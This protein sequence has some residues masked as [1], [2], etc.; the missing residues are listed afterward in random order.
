MDVFPPQIMGPNAPAACLK[1]D[2]SLGELLVLLNIGTPRRSRC[3][4]LRWA[5]VENSGVAEARP[6]RQEVQQ[7]RDGDPATRSRR[8]RLASAP[9]RSGHFTSIL[10]CS[11]RKALEERP[12]PIGSGRAAISPAALRR[13]VE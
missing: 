2:R 10:A 6:A 8:P 7:Q 12:E 1:Q 9:A 13:G 3:C 4:R 5:N 11:I